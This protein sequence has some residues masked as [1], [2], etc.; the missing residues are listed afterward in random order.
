[1]SDT[2]SGIVHKSAT[3]REVA[4][5]AGVSTT[6]VS[7]VV[8]GGPKSV[9][10]STEAKVRAAID[11]L[12]YRP[13][14][15]ARALTLGSSRVLG[16]VVPDAKSPFFASLARAVEDV[17][18]EYG[19]ALLMGNSDSS[20]AHEQRL[21]TDL[22]ARR[23]DGVVL[24]SSVLTPDLRELNLAGIPT[25]LLNRWTGSGDAPAVRSDLRAGAQM[26]VEHLI[27]QGHQNIGLLI[28]SNVEKY[29]DEREVGWQQAL[30]RAGVSEGKIV[31]APFTRRGGF[32][33]G[34]EFLL[35]SN[36]PTAIFASSDLQALGLLRAL[37]EARVR[38]P[39][40]IA[41]IGFDGSEEGEFSWP[42]LSTVAQPVRDMAR[43]ALDII[44]NNRGEDT[45][46]NL[47]FMPELILRPSSEGWPRHSYHS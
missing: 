13:N 3:R 30:R 46:A 16:I 1:M 4:Q 32:E 27:S 43:S 9:S 25:V 26:A 6:V 8:N 7:Y 42:P 18:A 21:I 38:I 47:V 28:G 39:E 33:A 45:L 34:P 12:G 31:R 36:P 24:C 41:V 35:Q 17:A 23:V 14:P 10:P 22:A 19:F 5:R 15:A 20:P 40:D 37:H 2:S 11:A 29:V 44:L